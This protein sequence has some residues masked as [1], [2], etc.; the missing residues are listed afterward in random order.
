MV[1]LAGCATSSVGESARTTAPITPSAAGTTTRITQPVP[2]D[3]VDALAGMTT[4]GAAGY[5]IGPLDILDV[6][7]FKVPEL[8]KT[9][10]V[11][12]FGRFGY[13]LVGEVQ[14]AGRSPRDL[15]KE[16]TR[17]LG[18]K[19]LRNPQVTVLVREY[20]SQRYT[21][22]GAVKKAGVFPMQ[23]NVTLMQ[24]IANAQGLEPLSDETLVIFRQ[25]D[26][27]ASIARFALSDLRSGK[28][29]DPMLKSGD[30]VMAPSS[31]MKEGMQ[32]LFKAAPL[33]GL[34]ALL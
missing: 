2:R 21:V 16:L 1:F 15:E 28:I 4:P 5:L 14:A 23:G 33:I 10:Q 25:I 3:A 26:G 9:V 27:Q 29:E 19:F 34:F 20:N 6:T 17:Q 12:E 18:D 24:A 32:T 8:S 11:S 7:V 30:I 13:P 31:D 22:E